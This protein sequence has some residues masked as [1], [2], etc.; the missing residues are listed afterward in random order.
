MV[1]LLAACA[2]APRPMPPGESGPV[3]VVVN[4]AAFLADLQP[5][6]VLSVSRDPVFGNDEGKLAK[7]V[8]MQFCASRNA[9]LNPRAYG[10]Y[11]GGQW[12]F[13]GGCA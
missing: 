10:H 5:G 1:S 8:A 12:L 2:G 6:P 7:D 3:G 4:G 13:K 11:L 9:R